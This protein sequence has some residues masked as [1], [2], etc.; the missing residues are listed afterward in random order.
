[1]FMGDRMKNVRVVYMGTPEFSLKPLEV[2]INKMNV[3]GVVTKPDA[4][5]GRKK[6]H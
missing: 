3:V 6:G 4:Y 5:V 2:L 1:M